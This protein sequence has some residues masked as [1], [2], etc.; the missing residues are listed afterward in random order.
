MSKFEDTVT[1]SGLSNNR[2][3]KRELMRLKCLNY[4]GGLRNISEMRNKGRGPYELANG[5]K[6]LLCTSTGID[7]NSFFYGVP[8]KAIDDYADLNYLSLVIPEGFFYIPYST[9]RNLCK[10]EYFS[11]G[12]KTSEDYKITIDINDNQ[13]HFR[14]LIGNEPIDIQ[15]YFIKF[16][17]F[18][19]PDELS[20]TSDD[21]IEGRKRTVTVNAYE[22]NPAAR[23][24]CIN[25]Y[26]KEG[27]VHC[28]ICGFDFGMVYGDTFEGMIHIHHLRMVSEAD[29][30]Y[31]VDPVTDLL[32]VCPN[33]HM[34]L[35]SKTNGCFTPDE[36]RE[37]LNYSSDD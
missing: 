13:Y 34:V 32:P 12:K 18:V 27:A 22:R 31:V 29:N 33:C 7:E 17:L 20:D 9:I 1:E 19:Y 24:A 15:A 25:H 8:K 4:L 28:Q 30:E 11:L 35:H 5:D 14:A 26:A 23:R 36:V 3:K 16:P 21:Y 6:I 37:M 10:N 2:L